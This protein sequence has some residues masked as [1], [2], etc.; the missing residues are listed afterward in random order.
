MKTSLRIGN[1]LIALL[2][3]NASAAIAA[4]Q[5]LCVNKTSGKL[6]I[7]PKCNKA[8]TLA[9][10]SLLTSAA[11][12]QTMATLAKQLT[13]GEIEMPDGGGDVGLIPLLQVRICV[14]RNT[15]GIILRSLCLPSED[16]VNNISKLI[17]PQGP[18]GPIGSQGVAGPQGE[19]GLQGLPGPQG[20]MG[21]QGIQGVQGD[22]VNHIYDSVGIKVGPLVDYGCT[23]FYSSGSGQGVTTLVNADGGNREVC[24]EKNTIRTLD[25]NSGAEL[26]FENSTCTGNGYLQESLVQ[27]QSNSFNTISFIFGVNPTFY[28]PISGSTPQQILV[29]SYFQGGVC[30]VANPTYNMNSML[31]MSP[32]TDLFSLFVPPFEIR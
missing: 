18:E 12:S 15:G 19:Q 27:V 8:E 24:L 29:S 11:Q 10:L 4:P 28:Y 1:I 26:Y 3:I 7:R 25:K 32:G 20:E 5:V 13:A 16:W 22:G 23:G 30:K 6:L 9:S 21:E 14:N 2:L 31:P 17:G